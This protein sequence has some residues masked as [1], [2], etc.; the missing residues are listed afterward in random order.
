MHPHLGC[1]E[2]AGDESNGRNRT[3]Q[4]A[5]ASGDEQQRRRRRLLDESNDPS[6]AA[7]QG[8]D[9]GTPNHHIDSGAQ[10]PLSTTTA[11][12]DITSTIHYLTDMLR[13]Q[14]VKQQK[15][16]PKA[17]MI[18]QLYS[19][20]TDHTAVDRSLVIYHLQVGAKLDSRLTPPNLLTPT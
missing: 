3:R 5:M 17:C 12:Q 9:A 1:L 11:Q 16:F 20:I 8:Q 7:V 13:P 14:R 10:H 18:H 6:P 4:P 19:L 15:Q 2:E